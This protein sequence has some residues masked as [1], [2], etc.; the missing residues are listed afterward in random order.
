M[1]KIAT[2]TYMYVDVLF[3]HSELQSSLIVF[4][5]LSVFAFKIQSFYKEKKIIALKYA[6]ASVT[7]C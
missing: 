6:H 3:L 4:Q 1:L 7:T 2:C 5:R